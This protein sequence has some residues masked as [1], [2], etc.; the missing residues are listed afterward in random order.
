MHQLTT[1]MPILLQMDILTDLTNRL[2][3]TTLLMEDLCKNVAFPK[4]INSNRSFAA[5][6]EDLIQFNVET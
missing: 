3:L 6:G 5:T 2:K 4:G 1:V